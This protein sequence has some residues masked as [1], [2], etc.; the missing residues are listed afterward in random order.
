[1]AR[2]KQ[3]AAAAEAPRATETLLRIDRVPAAAALV[4]GL[5]AAAS[6]AS[7]R[8]ADRMI[9]G[10][11]CRL[12]AALAAPALRGARVGALVVRAR[13]GAVLFAHDADASFAP[14]SN[15]K[16]LT[17]LG[18]LAR[19][20]PGH[21]FVT[22]VLADGAP[23]AAGR[24]GTLYLRGGGDP[25]L[26]SEQWW[27]LAA[28]LR[29]DGLRRAGRVV[30]DDGAFDRE[31][32]HPSWTPVGSRAYEAPIGAL[33]ANYGAF[34][35]VVRPGRRAGA[36]VEVAIDPPVAALGIV[37]RAVTVARTV[38]AQLGVARE[39]GPEG[40]RVIVTGFLP[41]D[42]GTQQLSRSVAD[43]TAYAGSVFAASLA[44]NGIELDD[45]RPL[46]G[47]T[48]ADAV[49][50]LAFE[51]PALGDSVRLLLEY[52]SN[53]IAEMLLKSLG[54]AGTGES[55]SFAS[56]ARALRAVLADL[57]VDLSGVEITDGSGLSTRNRASPR[58]LVSALRIARASLAFGP[59]LLAGLPVAARDGTLAHRAE[60]SRDR[61]RAK[62]GT[63]TGVLALSGFAQAADGEELVFSLLVNGAR[64]PSVAG[65]DGFAAA[66]VACEGAA[67]AEGAGGR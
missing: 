30:L 56:G 33:Q 46:A 25:G 10:D 3:P 18:A 36:P 61:V 29:R 51:G 15:Q 17:A 57:G 35:I 21:R 50:L 43:P 47:E 31:R 48:P 6:D 60:A 20:G 59:E 4:A 52:S 7:A 11:P 64:T 16:I 1:V 41:E 13:D 44:A 67:G 53:P 49:P 8:S 22:E 28:D 66:L 40:D 26:V 37:V 58:S 42:A 23:D 39:T 38:P 24:V 54:R 12:A 62:T 63:L 27:R 65:V 32:W 55:G 45:P 5:L 9:P 2:V 34:Q 14:A 19:F